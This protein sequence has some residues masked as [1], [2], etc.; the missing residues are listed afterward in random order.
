MVVDRRTQYINAKGMMLPSF[1]EHY[2]MFGEFAD[3]CVLCKVLLV[4]NVVYQGQRLKVFGPDGVQEV[5]ALTCKTCSLA[6]KSALGNYFEDMMNEILRMKGLAELDFDPFIHHFYSHYTGSEAQSSAC[7]ACRRSVRFGDYVEVS[8]PVL[9]QMEYTGGIIKI[10]KDCD[11][12]HYQD[13]GNSFS[14]LSLGHE[15]SCPTCMSRY[16]MAD[17][18]LKYRKKHG[19]SAFYCPSCT[20]ENI[21]KPNYPYNGEVTNDRYRFL[22]CP[23]GLTNEIDT[24]KRLDKLKKDYPL[25]ESPKIEWK[26]CK[27]CYIDGQFPIWSYKSNT[28]YVAVYKNTYG[29]GPCA[30]FYIYSNKARNFLVEKKI[31]IT[32]EGLA[33]V[34]DQAETMLPF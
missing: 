6:V 29:E 25:V 12:L 13:T 27:D 19:V 23:C 21:N 22:T 7:Y 31:E 24:C 14:S 26:Y 3:L 11:S 1:Y 34:I 28:I 30:R 4:S 18:E 20:Y 17:S 10:C 5:S 15:S 8:V 2:Q 9:R 32:V 16:T 33:S